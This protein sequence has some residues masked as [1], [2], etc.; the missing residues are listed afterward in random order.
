MSEPPAGGP[1]RPPRPRVPIDT[2]VL[3]DLVLA[4]A[5]FALDAA[6][7]HDAIARGRADGYV[8][9]HAVTTV[10][11]IVQKARGRAAAITAVGDLLSLLQV[12][13]LGATEFHRALAL[14]LRDFE[15]AVQAAACLTV[16]ADFLATRNASDFAG[17]PVTTVAPGELVAILA[18]R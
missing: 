13:A 5:P 2:N 16:G 17:A 10:H 12:V 6:L 11:Y 14:G 4:R 9:G 7:L 15:D 1:A 3:L 18:A 8:A